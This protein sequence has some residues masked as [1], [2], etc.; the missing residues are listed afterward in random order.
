MFC[1]KCGKEISKG[2]SYCNSCENL[3]GTN[4]IFEIRVGKTQF[5]IG[6]LIIIAG[7][8]LLIHGITKSD[9][10]EI[11]WSVIILIWITF[12]L[13]KWYIN[14]NSKVKLFDD[15]LI[16]DRRNKS[17]IKIH[18][19]DISEVNSYA[20]RYFI[21]L[22]PVSEKI[23][24]YEI[25]T[26]SGLK[27][28]LD[29]KISNLEELIYSIRL[30]FYTIMLPELRKK[31]DNGGTILFGKIGINKTGI[32]YGRKCLSWNDVGSIETKVGYL[33]IFTNKMY[34]WKL[35]S[36]KNIP[37]LPLFLSIKE[38]IMKEKYSI[39]LSQLGKSQ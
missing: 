36:L 27:L 17:E 24:T 19:H 14:L 28:T 21:N 2:S 3:V 7:V 6:L 9:F 39:Q 22:I 12:H 31:Y 35:V 13:R 33:E 4:K 20:T 25:K 8:A 15:G 16:Y 23:Y 10:V 30:N 1:L 11:A 32:F 29:D 37:N 5:I 26:N 34:R 38:D 18:W